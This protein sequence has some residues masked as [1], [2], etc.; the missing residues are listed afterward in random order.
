VVANQP[1]N[2]PANQLAGS[3]RTNPLPLTIIPNP[4]PP[5]PGHDPRAPQLDADDAESGHGLAADHLCV[6]R[7]RRVLRWGA[8]SLAWL[9]GGNLAAVRDRCQ[10]DALIGTVLW[11]HLSPPDPP[12]TKTGYAALGDKTPGNILTGFSH[13]AALV[14]AANAFVLVHMV[15]AEWLVRC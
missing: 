5:P 4:P 15:G 11:P 6:L 9:R 13:P 10:P 1:I 8:E 7:G 2:Q 14:T 3:T 12:P